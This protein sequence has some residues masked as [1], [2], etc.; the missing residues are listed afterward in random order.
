MRSR[1]ACFDSKPFFVCDSTATIDASAAPI[2]LARALVAGVERDVERGDVE[3]CEIDRHLRGAEFRNHPADRF[4][5]L[6]DSRLPLRL[7]FVVDDRVAVVVALH[8]A[9]LADVEGDARGQA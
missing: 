8:P 5:G 4:D 6:Q 2:A 3:I 9:A 7:A 1:S